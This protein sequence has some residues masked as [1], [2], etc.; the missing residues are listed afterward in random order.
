M[1]DTEII[2][3]LLRENDFESKSRLNQLKK[4]KVSDINNIITEHDIKLR[5]INNGFKANKN[6]LIDAIIIYEKML[7]GGRQTK[8]IDTK[9]NKSYWIK[10]ENNLIS[11]K[12]EPNID[13][14]IY[15]VIFNY[16]LDISNMSVKFEKST[17]NYLLKGASKIH[18]EFYKSIVRDIKSCKKSLIFMESIEFCFKIV[19]FMS[20]FNENG[21]NDI[22][23]N[24]CLVYLERSLY[25]YK[26]VR[27]I[28]I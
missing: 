27:C 17:K 23:R 16:C 7:L 22:I 5:N 9:T 15:H 8:I 20:I 21:I 24:I 19:L 25:D 4:L 18:V 1:S 14:D 12:K 11:I 10:T 2:I 6:M 28:L 13:H 3:S 26:D